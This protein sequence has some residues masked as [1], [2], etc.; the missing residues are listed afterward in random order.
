MLAAGTDTS[1]VSLEWAMAELVRNPR[2]MK[3]LQDEVRQVADGK[4]MVAEEDVNQ[5]GY[6]KAVIKEVLRLHPPAPILLP[7]E[8]MSSFSLQ[9]YHVPAKTRVIVNF[10]AIAR[11]PK[12][13]EGPEEFQPEWFMDNPVDY[14]GNDFLLI[15]IL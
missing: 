5:M 2:A 1:F 12:S 7:R 3:K 10:W 9:G 13:W 11:D 6:L 15:S 8:T 14:R 4:P